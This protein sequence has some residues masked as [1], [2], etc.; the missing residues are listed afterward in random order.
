MPEIFIGIRSRSKFFLTTKDLEVLVK[1]VFSG[2]AATLIIGGCST[3]NSDEQ[4]K[5]LGQEVTTYS[6]IEAA[7]SIDPGV[8]SSHDLIVDEILQHSV[9]L[10]EVQ[11][12]ALLNSNELKALVAAALSDMAS[13]EQ[14]GRMSNPRFAFERLSSPN[15]LELTRVLTLGIFDLLTLPKRKSLADAQVNLIQLSMTSAV[16]K[17]LTETKVAWVR[18]VAAEESREYAN[19]S[20]SSAAASAEL[21]KRMERVGNFNKLER[22]RE[23]IYYANSA[24][25]HALARHE[26]SMARENLARLL[27]LNSSQQR[28]LKL[29]RRLPELPDTIVGVETL[30]QAVNQSRIDI[31]LAKNEV[32]MLGEAQ[33]LEFLTSFTDVEMSLI[34]QTKLGGER[35]TSDGFELEIVLPVFDWG[36]QKREVMSQRTRSAVYRY[37]H[38]AQS[39]VIELRQSYETY[40]TSYDVA[41][42]YRDEIV[43]LQK[44]ISDENLLRYNGM[45]IGVFELLADSREQISAVLGAIE[46]KRKFWISHVA[47]DA[48][49]IGNPMSLAS[50]E[51]Q[52]KQVSENQGH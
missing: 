26:A 43:P 44:L 47:L 25:K 42:H 27:G 40:L 21:A 12:I 16:I 23:Q 36:D 6:E 51:I 48:S 37:Q 39:A 2:F 7:I 20:M 24:T 35:S 31:R 8:D 38:V 5:K 32:L 41:K 52:K 9:N 50:N 10:V 30:E 17:H 13:A 34:D 14:G 18:A 3:L 28:N 4:L 33:G 46:S 11:K 22:A 19:K 45:I 49:L 29:P 1:N 15:E